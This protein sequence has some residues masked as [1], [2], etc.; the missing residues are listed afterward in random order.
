MS[1]D[2][3]DYMSDAF[4]QACADTRPGL[5]PKHVQQKIEK[6]KHQ[7]SADIKS[8]TVPRHKLEA[9]QRE[10]GLKAS[11]APSSKGF[12][13]LQKMGYKPGMGIGKEGT[14]RIEP[15]SI[16]LKSGRSGLGRD[17]E[18]KRKATEMN[19]MRSI[20][21][22]KRRKAEERLHESFRDRIKDRFFERNV[23][24]DFRTAQRACLQLDQEKGLVE[25]EKSF[26]WPMNSV[27]SQKEEEE[28]EKEEKTHMHSLQRMDRHDDS[29]LD[30]CDDE[31]VDHDA[32][33][34]FS[35]RTFFL[36][37]TFHAFLK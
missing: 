4:L 15:V 18:I 12:A 22:A 17:T 14:G 9:T 5:V 11:I 29:D 24:R 19:Q 7:K 16:E 21:M 34:D 30:D 1:S 32:Y 36:L 23:E 6:E 27:P 35:V 2:D 26:F 8:R 10:A 33:Q 13:L 20:M 3:E 37:V 31:D 25:P 28:D